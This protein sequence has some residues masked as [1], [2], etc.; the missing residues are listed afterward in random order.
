MITRGRE[1]ILSIMHNIHYALKKREQEAVEDLKAQLLQR[2][3]SSS[4]QSKKL[5]VQHTFLTEAHLDA[6]LSHLVFTLYVHYAC[7]VYVGRVG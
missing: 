3:S 6:P 1:S 7:T 2:T 5:S 4:E